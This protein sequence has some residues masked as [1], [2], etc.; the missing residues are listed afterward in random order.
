MPG[1][2]MRRHRAAINVWPGWVDALATL[3]M[4]VMFLLMVFMVAQFYLRETLSGRESQLKR[5]SGQ[6]G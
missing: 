3:V 2:A 4:V 6:I 1:F 5:L